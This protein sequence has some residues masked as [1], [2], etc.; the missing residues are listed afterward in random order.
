M[1]SR[2]VPNSICFVFGCLAEHVCEISMQTAAVSDATLAHHLM[3]VISI[4]QSLYL[5]IIQPFRSE[6]TIEE[7]REALN[8]KLLTRAIA[9]KHFLS[10][11]S[12]SFVRKAI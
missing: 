12:A 1:H 5:D 10:V 6:S 7:P 9:S 2:I 11:I 8:Q 3:R 4:M